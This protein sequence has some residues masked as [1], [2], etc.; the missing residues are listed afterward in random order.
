VLSP[1]SRTSAAS[2]HLRC[3]EVMGCCSSRT[4]VQA[5]DAHNDSSPAS[6]L[7]SRTAQHAA[8][9]GSGPRAVVVAGPSGVGKG[10]LIDRLM[11][12]MYGKFGFSVSH[13]TRQPRPGE[14]DGVSY[15]FVAVLAMEAA[16]KNGE[17]VEYA[18]VHGNYYG[19]SKKSVS[20]VCDQGKVCILDIDVQGVKS[21]RDAWSTE[22]V[23]IAFTSDHASLLTCPSF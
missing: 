1:T 6:E 12:D 16:I 14:V 8:L 19:T 17:F 13:A 10:T 15:H 3:T 7:E 23:R 20:D 9:K 2:T 18:P 4:A 21:V 5:E 22:P 11:E